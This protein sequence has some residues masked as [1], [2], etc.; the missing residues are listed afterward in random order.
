MGNFTLFDSRWRS[1]DQLAA[2]ENAPTGRSKEQQL[3]APQRRI[4]GRGSGPCGLGHGQLG[5]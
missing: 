2:A 1:S 4:V 5:D 3:A